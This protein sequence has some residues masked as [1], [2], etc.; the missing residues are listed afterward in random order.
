M[1]LPLITFNDLN[2]MSDNELDE[3]SE[4]AWKLVRDCRA[5]EEFRKRLLK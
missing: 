5:I 1:K 3:V 2:L 4:F